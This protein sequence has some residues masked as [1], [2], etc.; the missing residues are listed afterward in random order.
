M[1]ISLATRTVSS[2]AHGS[3]V[4]L[5]F[6]SRLFGTLLLVAVVLATAA[7]LTGYLWVGYLVTT[8]S[9]LVLLRLA[10]RREQ[11]HLDERGVT[12]HG[13][14]IPWYRIDRA[15]LEEHCGLAKLRLHLDERRCLTINL[16]EMSP[17]KEVV[18]AYV[19]SR[20]RD[21]TGERRGGEHSWR[22]PPQTPLNG[23]HQEN[24]PVAL[25]VN[26]DIA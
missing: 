16:W 15:A 6:S 9:V 4:T 24:E 10:D 20:L 8:M 21:R 3:A 5:R 26:R 13:V 11:L 14:L 23:T 12:R 7:L 17:N 18:C 1:N 25:T 22:K 19:A 2:E